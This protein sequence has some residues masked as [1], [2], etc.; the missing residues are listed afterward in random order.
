MIEIRDLVKIYKGGTKALDRLCLNINPG[1]FGL[2]GPN[3]AGKTTLI[4]IIATLLQPT[5]GSVKVFGYDVEKE[6]IAIRYLLGYLPQD[7]GVYPNL[8][9]FEFLDY[10]WLLGNNGTSVKHNRRIKEILELVGLERCAQQKL[11][12]FS[13]G[14]RRRL[15]IA[16]ALLRDPSVLIVDEPTA[17]LDPEERIRFRNLL[18]EIS[19]NRVIL[20]STHIAEDITL[21]CSNMAIIKNGKLL[22]SGPPQSI[23]EKVKGKVWEALVSERELSEVKIHHRVVSV[24]RVTDGFKVRLI[25]GR[26]LGERV[27][28][29]LEDAYLY[30][31][32]KQEQ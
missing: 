5:S 17:G 2:L 3:G 9:A 7:F 20:L 31:V 26:N 12:T 16:Q 22:I 13:G 25:S 15:G 19:G 28:P 21:S 8:T 23:I 18:S 14:M 27:T 11:G 24:V 4:R 30:L 32:N 29:S 10:L 6:K 1:M